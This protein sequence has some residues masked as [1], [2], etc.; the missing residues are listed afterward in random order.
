MSLVVRNQATFHCEP[1]W[2]YTNKA[3]PHFLATHIRK[4]F[5]ETR[6][7]ALVEGFVLA[8][9]DL[10]SELDRTMSNTLVLT[11]TN[12]DGDQLKSEGQGVEEPDTGQDSEGL[13]YVPKYIV[14]VPA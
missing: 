8:N 3:L 10:R 4:G 9:S 13:R 11:S 5:D 6:V 2:F 1:I 7:G 14:S 12:S